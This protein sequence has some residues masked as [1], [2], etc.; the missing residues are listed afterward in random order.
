MQAPATLT[1]SGGS[2]PFGAAYV[3]RVNL[4]DAIGELFEARVW[5]VSSDPAVDPATVIG[6]GVELRLDAEPYVKT[7]VGMVSGLRQLTSLPSDDGA[8]VSSYECSVSPPLHLT[9]FRRGSRIYQRKTVTEI[10]A[11]ILEGYGGRIAPLVER[12]RR[13]LQTREYCVQYD[14]SDLDFIFRILSEEHLSAYFDHA[15]G[16][17]WT[18]VDE[19]ALLCPALPYRLPFRPP[20]N[21]TPTGPCA[22]AL[23]FED[24][25]GVATIDLRDYDFEH[26][27]LSR[28][29]PVVLSALR[30]AEG[31]LFS[32]DEE[33][34]EEHYEVGRFSDPRAG[35]ELA[36]RDLWSARWEAHV[37]ACETN[38][39]IGPGARLFVDDHPR[40]A[41]SEELLVVGCRFSVDDGAVPSAATQK[42]TPRRECLLDCVPSARG[43][44]PSRVP[45]PTLVGPQSAFVVGDF[46]SG[47]IDV[48]EYGRVLVEFVWDR[49]DLREGRPTR[50]VRVSQG[51]AGPSMGIVT[52][53]RIGDEVLVSFD[54]GD[55]DQPIVTG[56]VHNALNRVPLDLPE[57]DAA[58]SVWRS[59]TVGGDGFNQILM[60]D[61]PGQE[62]LEIRAERS[63]MDLTQGDE[64]SSVG[65]DLKIHVA[66][67]AGVEVKGSAGVRIDGSLAIG[68]HDTTV[69]TGEAF[70]HT[71]GKL[72]VVGDDA[73]ELNA[74]E[75]NIQAGKIA[76]RTDGASMVLSSTGISLEAS[77][78]SIK[79]GT[80]TIQAD[81]TVDVDGALIT[82]N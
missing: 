3:H 25:T 75:V 29:R 65:G 40:L 63:R 76:L 57:R 22:L 26:P 78:V 68:S 33:N 34:Q 51:W 23:E 27:Q 69:N 71:S 20:S 80:I 42:A 11:I 1:F 66:G 35:D 54:G 2:N 30:T 17:E 41:G 4:V 52:L 79:G 58:V 10:I 21:L 8:S 16:S 56:R 24:R 49:R 39:M 53:P 82:L 28:S 32:G 9:R 73:I 70:V 18:V 74:A 46:P 37:V 5:L 64:S 44:A 48:D 60:D 13:P 77:K 50:R 47:R 62:R 45:K 55:P 59:R 72:T 38:L 6:Q 7:I 15:R 43:F 61:K 19:P 14:E 31:G 67:D 36:R 81:G 12:L